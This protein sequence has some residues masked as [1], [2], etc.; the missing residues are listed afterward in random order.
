[1]YPLTSVWGA[2]SG[3]RVLIPDRTGYGRSPKPARFSPVFPSSRRPGDAGPARRPRHWPLRACGDTATAPSSPRSSGSPRPERCT[4]LVLEAFHYLRAKPG[5]RDFFQAAAARPNFFGD[6][7]SATLARAHGE[8]YWRELVRDHARAWLEIAR[9]PGDL[10]DGKLGALR[11]P[12]LFVHGGDDPRTE[13]G[14]LDAVRRALPKARFHVIAGAAHSPHSEPS[15]AD[16]VPP[17]GARFSAPVGRAVTV[18]SSTA[19]A[20]PGR[21]PCPPA[22]PP[23][24]HSWS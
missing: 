21:R 4:R 15:A 10:Y 9:L 8:P 6:R 17:R 20:S 12:S 23:P 18:R 19:S 22:R 16:G 5:S 24:A 2:R 3:F 7:L 11:V 14:E 1:M 13:P